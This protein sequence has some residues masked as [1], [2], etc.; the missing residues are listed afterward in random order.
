VAPVTVHDYTWSA[1]AGTLFI[2]G[3]VPRR[4]WSVRLL[5]GETIAK[6]GDAMG[7]G[8]TRRALDYFLAML[9][10]TQL[11]WM[12]RLTS[13][14]LS[15]RRLR[16]ITAGEVLKFVRVL[17]LGTRYQF[18]SRSEFRSTTARNKYI[19]APGSG[20]L[21]R[22][23]RDPFDSLSS[24]MAYSE[25]CTDPAVSFARR[26]WSLVDDFVAS[27]NAHRAAHVRPSDL[28]C[29]NQSMRKW[30]GQRGGWCDLGV[31]MYVAI[32]S[33]PQN[34]CDIQNTACG[35]SGIML[36]L[37]LMTTAGDQRSDLLSLR[38]ACFTGLSS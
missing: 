35:R 17:L 9:P 13:V 32:D 33:K 27:F 7:P 29:A 1:E 3:V 23:S 36:Y 10:L 12:V 4:S 8:R 21:T 25:E 18:G 6:E 24:C 34:G 14:K 16:A 26:R 11:S 5:S 15:A 22:M 30:Y 31:P 20:H 37:Q 28:L 19:P 38:A 2:G